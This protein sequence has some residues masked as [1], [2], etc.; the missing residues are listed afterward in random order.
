MSY[1]APPPAPCFS[2]MMSPLRFLR[3]Q[4]TSG[5]VYVKAQSQPIPVLQQQLARQNLPPELL[6]PPWLATG[7]QPLLTLWLRL[8]CSVAP[9]TTCSMH[10]HTNTAVVSRVLTRVLTSLAFAAAACMICHDLPTSTFVSIE[11]PN[12]TAAASFFFRMYVY[13]YVFRR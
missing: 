6:L 1:L 11:T 7:W 12:K 5:V 2:L 13:T 4:C 8:E 10:V 9:G 3:H